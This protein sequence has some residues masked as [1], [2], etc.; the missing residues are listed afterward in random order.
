MSRFVTLNDFLRLFSNYPDITQ[1]QLDRAEDDVNAMTF[2]RLGLCWDR[3]DDPA[4]QTVTRAICCQAL[5]LHDYGEMI[6]NPMSSYGING[7][8]MSWKEDAVVQRGGVV[9]S[10]RVYALLTGLG[11]TYRGLDWRC[12]W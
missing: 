6:D 7:V 9:V 3:M 4:R 12:P 8:S 5:F 10:R 2:N 1:Q 11:L